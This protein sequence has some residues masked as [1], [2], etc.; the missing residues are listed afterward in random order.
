ME[1]SSAYEGADM[2]TIGNYPK[3]LNI[4]NCSKVG[5]KVFF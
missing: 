1:K 2:E 4:K 3:F 5:E